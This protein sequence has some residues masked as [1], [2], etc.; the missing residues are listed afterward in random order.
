[1]FLMGFNIESSEVVN[2]FGDLQLDVKHGILG[3]VAY[4]GSRPR[5]WGGMECG[6]RGRVRLTSSIF[7]RGSL[8]G[9]K[10]G[11]RVVHREVIEYERG[12]VTVLGE[13][14]MVLLVIWMTV[15]MDED[16]WGDPKV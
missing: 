11:E 3:D 13:F 5:A 16:S 6:R 15:F 7:R 14:F 10:L 1:M 2:E 12:S 8:N 4:G 9:L